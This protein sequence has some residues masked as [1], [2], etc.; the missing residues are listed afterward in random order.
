M[1]IE[2][3]RHKALRAFFETGKA[4]GL[5]GDLVERL[6]KMLALIVDADDLD[7]LKTPPNYGFHV[8]T[9][10]RAGEFAMA[11]SRNWRMTFGLSGEQAIVNLDLEDYH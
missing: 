9:G 6:R 8:L 10:N 1:E 11:V 5:P 7:E 2:S 4:K 3:I